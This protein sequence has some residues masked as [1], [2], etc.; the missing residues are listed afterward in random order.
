MKNHLLLGALSLAV[1][2]TAFGQVTTVTTQATASVN[3]Y[4]DLTLTNTTGLFFGDVFPNANTAGKVTVG[5]DGTVSP[6]TV[7]LGTAHTGY[8]ATYALTGK[9]S[10]SFSLTLP[11][12]TQLAAGGLSVDTWTAK[13]DNGAVQTGDGQQATQTVDPSGHSTIYLGG[14]LHVPAAQAEGNYSAPY[15]VTVAYN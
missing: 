14:T 3:I 4:V 7:T 13:V 8:A 1:S 10:S 6:T 12:S 9:K 5:T 15:N 11:S 2:M